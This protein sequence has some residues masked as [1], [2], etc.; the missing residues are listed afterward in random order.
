MNIKLLQVLGFL[1][2][3][4][5]LFAQTTQQFTVGVESNSQYYIDDEVTGDFEEE[6]PFRSNNYIKLAYDIN[7][8]SFGL[9]LEGYAPQSLLNYSPKYDSPYNI[10]V[11][12][13]AYNTNKFGVTLGH[14]YEQFGSGLILRS[15]EDRQLGINNAIRGAKVTFQP[16]DK[17][18]MTALYGQQRVGFDVSD[19]QLFGFDTNFDLSSEENSLQVGASYVGR[20]QSVRDMLSS[21]FEETELN[22]TTHAV[23]GRLQYAK[24]NFFTNIEGVVKGKDALVEGGVQHNDKLFYGNALQLEFGYSKKGFGLTASLRRMENMSFYSDR[25]AAGNTYN[26]QTI[27]YI[28]GL[29][30]LHDYG[31]TNIYVYQAQPNLSFNPLE[32]AGEIGTQIDL[33][34]KFNKDTPIGGK[35]GT[36]VALNFSNWY[37]LGADYNAAYQRI[38]VS[39]LDFGEQYFRDINIEVRKKFSKSTSGIFA[40]V[41]SYYNK[42]YIEEKG[43][44]VNSNILVADMTYKFSR[45]QSMRLDA[46]HL[47]TPDDKKN[48]VASTAEFN[49]NT[50]LS[51]FATDM[52]NYGNDDENHRDH[53]FNMGGSYTH[54]KS[55]FAL[56]YGRTRGGLLCVGG[57]CREVPAATGLTFNLTTSF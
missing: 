34:Y 33:Y 23:S 31:L 1:L 22:P 55:R 56:S 28:P 44:E 12:S 52:Y 32:K 3:S 29:T 21:H 48:W 10:G 13:A 45:K 27:N 11:F 18:A 25:L 20:Y 36:K 16:T 26:E 53:Y 6:D 19:G 54:H 47:W 38:D 4:S 8:F 49:V 37:G 41:N 50:H 24:N 2:I 46:Q 5:V 39:A 40:F 30:K 51:F 7:E 43:E 42:P 35:Y 9:Q 17:I 15:W 57:V 14:F